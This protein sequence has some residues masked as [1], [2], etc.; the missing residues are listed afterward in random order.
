M[1]VYIYNEITIL[2]DAG[3]GERAVQGIGVRALPRGTLPPG[4]GLLYFVVLTVLF[5]ALT[6]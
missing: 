2:A 4:R 1:Y 6:V 3:E 5:V